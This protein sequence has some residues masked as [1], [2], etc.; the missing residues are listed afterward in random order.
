MLEPQGSWIFRGRDQQQ[1][2]LVLHHQ[3]SEDDLGS[4]PQYRGRPH[5]SWVVGS[6]RGI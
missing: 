1:G 5:G 2:K 3:Q 4:H 6:D